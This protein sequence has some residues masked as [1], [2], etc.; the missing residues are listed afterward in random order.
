LFSF[1]FKVYIKNIRT[2]HIEYHSSIKC[3]AHQTIITVKIFIKQVQLIVTDSIEILH[4]S[5]WKSVTFVI[6]YRKFNQAWTMEYN[7]CWF[8]VNAYNI[9]INSLAILFTSSFSKSCYFIWSDQFSNEYNA[10]ERL[11]STFEF[12][13]F[14]SRVFLLYLYIMIT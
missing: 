12:V 11:M 9:N 7:L 14:P 6:L 2:L 10:Y 4:Y 5:N 3:L 13:F 8:G 1:D